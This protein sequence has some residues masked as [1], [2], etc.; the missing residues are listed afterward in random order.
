MNSI[1]KFIPAKSQYMFSDDKSA[2]E[3]NLWRTKKTFFESKNTRCINKVGATTL[4]N[5]NKVFL[6]KIAIF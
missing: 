2:L 4:N 1:C 3:E 5:F 6:I